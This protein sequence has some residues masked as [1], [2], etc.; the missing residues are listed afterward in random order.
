M[1]EVISFRLPKEEHEVFVQKAKEFALNAN[2]YAKQLC[3]ES[4]SDGGQLEELRKVLLEVQ[5]DVGEGRRE[6]ME[7]RR[8]LAL[9]AA[10]VL[11]ATKSMSEAD[12]QAWC[13]KNLLHS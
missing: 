1:S 5:G 13:K 11:A 8:D 10:L 6:L 2:G 9:C 3:F 12:A 4:V 7:L